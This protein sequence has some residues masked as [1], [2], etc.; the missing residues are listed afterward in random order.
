[1]PVNVPAVEV[2]SATPIAVDVPPAV[3]FVIDPDPVKPADVAPRV[4]V[5]PSV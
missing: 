4:T 2:F 5:R 1:M 3:R